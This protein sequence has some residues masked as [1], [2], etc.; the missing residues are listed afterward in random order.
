MTNSNILGPRSNPD[1]WEYSTTSHMVSS[2]RGE[3]TV[4]DHPR[5]EAS[6]SENV[7]NSTDDML[8]SE[9]TGNS[10]RGNNWE[11]HE[12][13]S[14]MSICS[15]T[16]CKCI[17]DLTGDQSFSSIADRFTVDLAGRWSSEDLMSEASQR[18]QIEEETAWEYTNGMWSALVASLFNTDP[19]S[20][21]LRRRMGSQAC[22]RPSSRLCGSFKGVLPSADSQRPPSVVCTEK[23]GLRLRLSLYTHKRPYGF[24]C[25]RP[26]Q[27]GQ[28]FQQCV[29]CTYT[30]P[31]AS[32]KL[33]GHSSAGVNGKF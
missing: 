18:L 9:H 32:I 24:V 21:F 26:N 12:P 29:I 28:I 2:L 31:I 25:R 20:S 4:P 17:H 7:P 33:V 19:C 11:Y 30:N 8:S 14:W 16:A 13:W 27:G 6:I 3:S 10:L 22:H 5:D 1:V 15:Q 23:H